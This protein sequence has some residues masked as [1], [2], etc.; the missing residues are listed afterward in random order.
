MLFDNLDNEVINLEIKQKSPATIEQIVN[1]EIND[2]I[3][4]NKYKEMELA[5]KYYKNNN[6]IKRE[7]R[8]KLDGY[9]HLTPTDNS[10]DSRLSHD[11]FSLLTD[12]K[13]QYLLE[14]EWSIECENQDYLDK[15]N[16]LLDDEFK[17]KLTK[18]TLNAIT[19]SCG[20]GF[21][22]PWGDVLR[23]KVVNPLNLLPLWANEDHTELNAAIYFYHQICYEGLTKKIKKYAQFWDK[24]GMILLENETGTYRIVS[25]RQPMITVRNGE[26]ISGLNWDRIPFI[27][28]R[29]NLEEISLLHKIKNQID[30][31]D[32]ITS[33]N[34]NLLQDDDNKVLWVQNY[35]GQSGKELREFMAKYRLIKTRDQGSVGIIDTTVDID[36]TGKHLDRLRKDIFIFGRGVDPEADFGANASAEARKYQYNLL[37][38]DCN[39]LENGCKKF[40]K[41]Y[42]WFVNRFYRLS[43]EKINFIFN[44]DIIT[45]ES[46]AIDMCV[47]SQSINGLSTKTILSNHPWVKDVDEEMKEW[48]AENKPLD[49]VDEGIGTQGEK[50][51]QIEENN[52]E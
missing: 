31:Y 41:D 45:S 42:L 43:D 40:I 24:N 17:T 18:I 14:K 9:G 5:E 7:G 44:R 22:Y 51:S 30:D 37:D 27:P 12:Q 4:S 13:I 47:K 19:K 26:T 48:E 15:I 23:L 8:K 46:S 28:L 49:D 36:N 16:L 20:W 35:D 32:K 29:Y 1:I 2:Y 10:A 39:S 3:S 34:S 25:G 11:F 38:M 50:K 52:N 6:D 21:V 33:Q